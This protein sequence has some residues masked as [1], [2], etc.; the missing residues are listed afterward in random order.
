MLPETYSVSRRSSASTFASW[1]GLIS[2]A[3]FILDHAIEHV[4]W[5]KPVGTYVGSGPPVATLHHDQTKT[6]AMRK[7]SH[8]P[9]A[10]VQVISHGAGRDPFY[11]LVAALWAGHQ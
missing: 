3:L 10:R 4:T 6:C 2:T 8:C 5:S 11:E 1:R 7:T 9:T